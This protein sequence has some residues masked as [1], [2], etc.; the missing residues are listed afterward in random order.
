MH[1]HVMHRLSPSN[2]RLQQKSRPCSHNSTLS[3]KAS[4]YASC[5]FIT[6]VLFR[7]AYWL[8]MFYH[9]I[10]LCSWCSCVLSYMCDCQCG[11]PSIY[12][13]YRFG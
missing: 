4:Y 12:C 2:K 11:V 6:R 3:C 5:N 9:R 8:R 10:L 7:E 13:C 1:N